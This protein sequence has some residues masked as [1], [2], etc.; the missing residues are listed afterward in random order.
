MQSDSGWVTSEDALGSALEY[1]SLWDV[2][3]TSESLA[4]GLSY[5]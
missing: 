5:R 2:F 4:D 3:L 1:L